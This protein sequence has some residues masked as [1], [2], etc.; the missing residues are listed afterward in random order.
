MT[1]LSLFLLIG[2]AF[3]F[4]GALISS[5]EQ[6]AEEDYSPFFDKSLKRK[7][8]VPPSKPDVNSSE[9]KNFKKE[10]REIAKDLSKS[11]RSSY[12]FSMRQR[13]YWITIKIV[14]IGLA[15]MGFLYKI[16]NNYGVF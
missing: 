15:L 13:G 7:H 16:I 10:A 5:K 11:R 12:E 2:F 8:G 14:F 3:I 1:T 9:Y 4:G 6:E